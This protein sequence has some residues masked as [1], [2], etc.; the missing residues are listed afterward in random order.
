MAPPGPTPIARIPRFRAHAPV[1]IHPPTSHSAPVEVA[2]EQTRQISAEQSAPSTPLS[3]TISDGV[4][5][6]RVLSATP[7]PP[8]GRGT[9]RGRRERSLSPEDSEERVID[10]EK[11]TMAELCRDIHIGRKSKVYDKIL[12]FRQAEKERKRN[13]VHETE[14]ERQKRLKREETEEKERKKNAATL[15]ER[16]IGDAAVDG[17]K[18]R[19]VGGKIIVDEESLQVDRHERDARAEARPEDIE[20]ADE[21]K[22]RVNSA[23]WSRRERVERWN[24]AETMRFYDALSMWGTDFGLIAQ[25]FGG[26]SRRQIKNK[27]NS[28]ERKNPTRVHMALNR[29]LPVDEQFLKSEKSQ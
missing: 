2:L 1:S 15:M 4:D 19:V 12:E 8:P 24:V 10:A 11:I 26:R 27:F 7:S 21:Y 13:A 25:M 6:A 20:T 29:R 3:D 22:R 16:G 28:E 5:E 17:P 23:S 14:E 18:L 9:H